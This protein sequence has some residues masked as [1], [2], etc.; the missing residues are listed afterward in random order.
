MMPLT[1]EPQ[2][3]NPSGCLGAASG[4]L[5]A[6]V[7]SRNSHAPLAS[8]SND[9]KRAGKRHATRERSFLPGDSRRHI[10]QFISHAI[11][12][13]ME[14]YLRQGSIGIRLDSLTPWTS[15]IAKAANRRV[16]R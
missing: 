13:K 4:D 12:L 5:G 1:G 9:A 7:P 8:Q 6:F 3:L 11:D 16:C 2:R 15:G 14:G 10:F